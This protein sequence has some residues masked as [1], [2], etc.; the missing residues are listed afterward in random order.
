M[1]TS[2][3]A[4]GSSSANKRP[5]RDSSGEDSGDR[6]AQRR[7]GIKP[8]ESSKKADNDSYHLRK[9]DLPD[10]IAGFK[11]N[12]HVFFVL[13]CFT[14]NSVQSALQTHIRILFGALSNTSIPDT[15]DT[16]LIHTFEQR[17]TSADEVNNI[18]KGTANNAIYR[19]ADK[20]ALKSFNE[21]RAR[22][23]ADPTSNVVLAISHVPENIIRLIYSTVHSFGLAAWRPDLLGGTPTSLYN[24]TLETIAIATF[25]QAASSHGYRRHMPNLRYL[26]ETNMVQ[27]LYRNFVWSYMKKLVVKEAKE[28]GS[29]KRSIEGNKVYKN[30]VEVCA[31]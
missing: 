28:P 29:V 6:P 17:F 5:R 4:T 14:G 16:H 10:D 22:C 24:A 8:S 15:P 3:A 7:R 13:W 30:R 12:H 2:A 31:V 25:E 11:V 27:Q 1:P 21:L 23:S 9:R 19:N 18:L 20:L 26:G